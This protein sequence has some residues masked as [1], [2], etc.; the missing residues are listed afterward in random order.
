[1]S[2]AS[3]GLA[4][5][6]PAG[7][8][9][10]AVSDSDPQQTS[11]PLVETQPVKTRSV[12]ISPGTSTQPDEAVLG[13]LIY[14]YRPAPESKLLKWGIG[15]GG[16]AFG[17]VTS[18]YAGYVAY[19][20]YQKFGLVA[21]IS[22]STPWFILGGS[23]LLLWLAIGVFLWVRAQ[24]GV[25]L[26]ANGLFIEDRRKQSLT[27]EQIDGIAQGVYASDQ[28]KPRDIRYQLRIFPNKGRS[29]HLHGSGDGKRGIP[30]LS[31]LASR[32]KSSLYPVLQVELARMYRGG[33]PL[34]FGPVQIDRQG[35]KIPRRSP[36]PG[37]LS[38]PWEQV[39]Q[40]TVQSGYF[41]VESFGR[42]KPYRLPVSRIPNLEILLKIIDQSVQP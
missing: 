29:V 33:L 11:A 24:P 22:R 7:L 25:R 42:R 34:R 37:T 32:I 20:I 5:A 17:L 38:V 28:M 40:I 16:A 31:E 36:F 12:R 30:Y 9:A 26:H 2:L 19:S 18:G 4:P 10:R 1:V 14:A 39:K 3:A 8:T 6:R 35:L 23:V 41:L 27:W 13:R 21:A 15:L